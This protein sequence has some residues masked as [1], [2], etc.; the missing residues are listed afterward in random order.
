MED[1]SER[2]MPAGQVE[3]QVPH[4]GPVQV[5]GWAWVHFLVETLRDCTFSE[6]EGCVAFFLCM[7]L[8][9]EVFGLV[10]LLSW[11]F[12]KGKM[13]FAYFFCG[14]QH[15]M[16]TQFCF[17]IFC[18]FVK[19]FVFFPFP[20]SDN[21]SCWPKKFPGQTFLHAK[22]DPQRPFS[23]DFQWKRP[24]NSICSMHPIKNPFCFNC[25]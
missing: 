8:V 21:P 5:S 25:P 18:F 16:H 4:D 7:F 17:S 20:F 6:G 24:P 22:L 1:F 19:N 15:L 23:A 10:I 12:Q 9:G 11:G 2:T 14:N 3:R 13:R